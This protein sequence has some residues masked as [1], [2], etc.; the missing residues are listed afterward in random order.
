M[1]RDGLL[2]L[3][4]ALMMTGVA[5]FSSHVFQ[6]RAAFLLTGAVMAT[7]MSANVYFWI[8]PGQRRM[9]AALQAEGSPNPLDGKRGKQR[10]VHNTYFTLPVVFLMISNHY[11][12]AYS[13]ETAWFIMV[14]FILT[15]ALIRQYFVLRHR[16]QNVLTLPAASGILLLIIA[17]VAAPEDQPA[18]QAKLKPVQEKQMRT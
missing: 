16:G 15:G 9:V 3:A 4:V 7:C 11:A 2:S 10:S 12:F 5:Y 1:Q 14:L 18:A 6:G 8:I 13:K 17:M